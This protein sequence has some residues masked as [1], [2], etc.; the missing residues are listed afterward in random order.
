M[1]LKDSNF[2]RLNYLCI[3]KNGTM[4]NQSVIIEKAIS[5]KK[6]IKRVKSGTTS[7]SKKTS[8]PKYNKIDNTGI[9]IK[10]KNVYMKKYNMAR[11]KSNNRKLFSNIYKPY[12]YNNSRINTVFHYSSSLSPSTPA[13]RENNQKK[14][15]TNLY[16]ETISKPNNNNKNIRKDTELNNT[17]KSIV[18]G[19]F[20]NNSYVPLTETK[21][22]NLNKHKTYFH[23]N[24]VFKT[25]SGINFDKKIYKISTYKHTPNKKR[26]KF[27]NF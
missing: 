22:H 27:K 16:N 17:H 21:Y 9:M 18:S 7:L 19:N 5:K 15:K 26:S 24:F 20:I 11:T 8:L 4:A 13:N 25:D 1:D 10:E 2:F 12:H 3:N 14:Y 6:A 23:K